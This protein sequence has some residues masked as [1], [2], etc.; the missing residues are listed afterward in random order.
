MRKGFVSVGAALVIFAVM[1]T[2]FLAGVNIGHGDSSQYVIDGTPVPA[3]LQ[4]PLSDLWQGYQHLTTDSYWRPFDGQQL[5]YSATQGMMAGCCNGKDTH[6]TFSPPVVNQP[7][8]QQLDESTY[9]IG[10]EVQMTS[11]GLEITAPFVDSPAQRAGLRAGDVIVKVNGVDV[12]G[13]TADA[14]VTLIH[15]KNGTDV[16]LLISRPGRQ[17]T[18]PVTVVRGSIPTVIASMGADGVGYIQFSEFAL[19]TATEVQDAIKGLQG[20]H[21]KRLILDL[22]D[23]VGGYVDVAQDIAGEFLPKGTVI[24]WERS[25]LGNNK[26]QDV[27]ITVTQA[28]IAQH[29]PVVV[30]VNGSTASAAE[31]LTAALQDHHRAKVVGVTTYG[32]GSEQE[33]LNLEDGSSLRITIHLWLTPNKR[34][35]DG[36]GITPDVVVQQPSNGTDLQLQR[37]AQVLLT[38]H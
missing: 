28:G 34:Q 3:A 7:I 33:D 27:P 29:L 25:N 2:S 15:G 16:H 32:K 22:R 36:K 13:M 1:A 10:A 20:M 6:T 38:G 21:M 11:V 4:Q 8:V 9:G 5:I 31:I 17:G 23:N 26:Y 19:H 30:L 18:F 14:A 24:F 37:A 12:R 35:I